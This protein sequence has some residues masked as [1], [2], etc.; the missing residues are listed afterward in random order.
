VPTAQYSS[1]DRG[2]DNR[3]ANDTRRR[4]AILG[5]TASPR[6]PS[7]AW[8]KYLAFMMVAVMAASA[9]VLVAPDTGEPEEVPEAEI[10]ATIQAGEREVSYTISRYGESYLKDTSPSA[11][12]RHG[13]TPG[14]SE[15]WTARTA[16]YGDTIMHNEFPYSVGY[17]PNSALETYNKIYR[18]G[19][20]MV[21]FY[22]FEMDARNVTTLGTGPGMDPNLVPV[23]GN[24]ANDGGNVDFNWYMTYLTSDEVTSLVAGTHYA[25]SYYSVPALTGHFQGYY[26][27]E[28]WY[29][30]HQGTVTFDRSGAQ[31]FLG[32]PGVGPDLRTEFTTANTGGALNTAYAAHFLAEGGLGDVFNIVPCYDYEIDPVYY[33][34]S[35]DPASTEDNLV[36]RLWGYSW[37]MDAMMLR[38]MDVPGLMSNFNVWPEDWYLNGTITSSQADVQSRMVTFDHL[39]SWT[40]YNSLLAEGA[41]GKTWA[42]SWMMEPVHADWAY[43]DSGGWVSQYNDYSAFAVN[44]RP[45][46]EMWAPGS[47]Y[48]G[49]DDIH[50]LAQTAQGVA[51][52]VTPRAWDLVA[53]ETIEIK[54]AD[55]FW[56]IEPYKG[57]ATEDFKA[58]GST[59]KVAEVMAHGYWGEMVL[60]HGPDASL[61]SEDYYDPDTK[62][63]TYVGP[64]NFEDHHNDMPAYSDLEQTGSP[65]TILSVSR[66][67]SYSMR[68]VEP[69][70]Y[71]VGETYT[72]EVTAKNYTDVTVTDWN[73]T[74][75]LSVAQGGAVLGSSSLTFD[76]VDGG[77]ATTTIEF[78]TTGT[79]VIEGEDNGFPLDVEGELT[80]SGVE[81][82]EFP[83]L[84][85][86]VIGAVAVFVALRRRKST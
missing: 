3:H 24:V 45:G 14:L 60:G 7:A 37:G 31:K 51:Y 25:N 81:I 6:G 84:L 69:G 71:W 13:S 17:A 79:T 78:T 61:Y 75:D 18:A 74:V 8:R 82:P 48:Y 80:V 50:D 34:L 11:M 5:R 12:G 29:F 70:P 73:G 52:W 53:G 27:S 36:V 28:G 66:V 72:L 47:N 64:M 10:P 59:V 9:L 83:T 85:I 1:F 32:L 55:R 46:K 44:Y 15:W 33:W 30:E 39:T 63:I 35:L 38:F 68:I 58:G 62:T 20:I 41:D 16:I 23:L 86:P 19:Y 26:E 67:S 49:T 76:P 57:V 21:S 56:A 77:V 4:E 40:D 65:N 43:D 54:L 22:R 2:Y 42:G